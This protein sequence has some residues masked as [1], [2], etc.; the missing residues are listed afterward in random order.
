M[1]ISTLVIDPIL[2]L[3]YAT[4]LLEHSV[5]HD[6]PDGRPISAFLWLLEVIA[7]LRRR[8]ERSL[9]AQSAQPHTDEQG[10]A[11]EHRANASTGIDRSAK[12]AQDGHVKA[13]PLGIDVAEEDNDARDWTNWINYMAEVV[14]LP[15]K[16][17]P[18]P[19]LPIIQ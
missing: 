5:Q 9:D 6:A 19:V 4:Q 17:D 16:S 18:V 13:A 3:D 11:E 14:S 7:Y 12:A 2:R 15:L 1:C 10:V 8:D